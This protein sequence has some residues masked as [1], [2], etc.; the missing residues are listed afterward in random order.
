MSSMHPYYGPSQRL[1]SASGSRTLGALSMAAYLGFWAAALV[2]AKREL[3]AR[4]P[5]KSPR[6]GIDD[7]AQEILRERFARGEIDAGQF[8]EMSRVLARGSG[9]V[10]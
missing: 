3:D 10:G 7:H 6:P 8:R 4:F 2:I 9:G 1:L 5:R